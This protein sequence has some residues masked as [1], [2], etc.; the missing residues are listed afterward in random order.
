MLSILFA[1]LVRLYT[2]TDLPALLP[3]IRKNISLTYPDWRCATK[4]GSNI[5]VEE[6]DWLVFQ[7]AMPSY[8]KRLL[9]HGGEVDLILAVDCIYHPSLLS[10]L[11]ETID[12]LTTPG[13]TSVIVVVELRADEVVREFMRLWLNQSGWDIRRVGTSLMGNR[14]AVWTGWKA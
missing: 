6:I 9:P 13:K 11:V 3:L 12:M 1:P 4:P 14:Y 5:S 7:D 10:A 2:V 8:R